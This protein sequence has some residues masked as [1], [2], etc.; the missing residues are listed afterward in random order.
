MIEN[1]NVLVKYRDTW[2]KIKKALGIKFHSQPVYDAK[3]MKAELKGFNGV[4][5]TNFLINEVPK[6]GFH[7]ACIACIG[8]DSE[9]KMEKKNYPQVYLEEC[10]YKEKKIKMPEFIDVEL[11]SDS[12]S[13]SEWLHLSTY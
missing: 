12:S 1:D 9:T 13:G 10:K 11:K 7:Y 3:Y 8:I 2:N 4:V 6:E 5:N